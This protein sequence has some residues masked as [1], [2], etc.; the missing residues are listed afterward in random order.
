MRLPDAKEAGLI[1]QRILFAEKMKDLLDSG[2]AI[3]Y[4]DESTF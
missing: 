2:R 3:I 1:P 4:A